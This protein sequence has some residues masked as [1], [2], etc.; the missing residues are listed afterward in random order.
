[1]HTNTV[2]NTVPKELLFH[3]WKRTKVGKRKGLG[4]TATQIIAFS[5]LAP[6]NC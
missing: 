4:N 2:T 1:M 5:T 3:H 6:H